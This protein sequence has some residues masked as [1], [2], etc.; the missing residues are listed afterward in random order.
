MNTET[1]SAPV[2]EFLYIDEDGF[3]VYRTNTI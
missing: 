1:Q 2:S 3:A